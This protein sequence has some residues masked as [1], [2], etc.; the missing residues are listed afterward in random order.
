MKPRPLIQEMAGPCMECGSVQCAFCSEDVKD[1]V[2]LMKAHVG[3][4]HEGRK[5]LLVHE[6][7]ASEVIGIIDF[8]FPVFKESKV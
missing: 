5:D 7:K 4:I 6:L 8:C 1:A 3:L 2:A